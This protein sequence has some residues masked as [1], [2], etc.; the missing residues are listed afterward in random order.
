MAPLS[1]QSF[2]GP[3]YKDDVTTVIQ[4][5]DLLFSLTPNPIDSIDYYYDE[6]D[7]EEEPMSDISDDES[8]DEEEPMR[9]DES[10]DEEE[11]VFV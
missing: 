9:D 7:D 1:L 4:R 11:P 10:D 5:F 6:S 8:D 2:N 3:I